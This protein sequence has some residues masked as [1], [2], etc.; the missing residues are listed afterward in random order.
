VR[1][2]DI[3]AL[4][5]SRVKPVRLK[6]AGSDLEVVCGNDETWVEKAALYF[7]G[8]PRPRIVAIEMSRLGIQEGEP[9]GWGEDV[10]VL[11]AERTMSA[12][13]GISKMLLEGS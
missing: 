5:V 11:T 7:G 4:T 10:K 3:L 9:S 2:G 13:Y 8:K 12:E 6:T 1:R